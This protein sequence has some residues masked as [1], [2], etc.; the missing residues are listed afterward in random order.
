MKIKSLIIGAFCCLLYANLWAQTG[1]SIH[2]VVVKPTSNASFYGPTD[3]QLEAEVRT[4]EVFDVIE[5]I[6]PGIGYRNIN[7][8]YNAD[9]LHSPRYD[10]N[11]YGNTHLELT[12]KPITDS[13]EWDKVFVRFHEEQKPYDDYLSSQPVPLNSWTTISIPLADYTSA[14][15]TKV[16]SINIARTQ[17]ADSFRLAIKDIRFTG[18]TQDFIWFGPSKPGF[19]HNGY[20][21][22]DP[23]LPGH[24]MY[25]GVFTEGY[26]SPGLINKVKFYA[27]GQNI[28]YDTSDPYELNWQDVHVGSYELKSIAE[29][30][31]GSMH[32]SDGVHINVIADSI[33]TR[34]VHVIEPADSSEFYGPRAIGLVAS[35]DSLEGPTYFRVSTPGGLRALNIGHHPSSYFA[36]SYDVTGGGNTHLEFQYRPQTQ[37]I[38]WDNVQVAIYSHKERFS[39][40]MNPEDTVVGQWY[41]ASIPLSEYPSADF[42]SMQLIQIPY[43]YSF[44]DSAAIDIGKIQFVGGAEP[45]LWFGGD[46]IDNHYNGLTE[47]DVANGV[48]LGASDVYADKVKGAAL[49]K[50]NFFENGILIGFDSIAPFN[51]DNYIFGE[52]THQIHAAAE[53]ADGVSLSSDPI[54]I[55]VIDTSLLPE[56]WVS[57]GQLFGAGVRRAGTAFDQNE[58]TGEIAVAWIED[59]DRN[60]GGDVDMLFAILDSNFNLLA[61]PQGTSWPLKLGGEP[62]LDVFDPG[63]PKVKID[64]NTGNIV[65]AWLQLSTDKNSEEGL[66]H[67]V[68][69]SSGESLSA[70]QSNTQ[71]LISNSF[72]SSYNTFDICIDSSGT[73]Y[74]AIQGASTDTIWMNKVDPSTGNLG[75]ANDFGIPFVDPDPT[76][77]TSQR[78]LLADLEWNANYGLILGEFSRYEAGS[79]VN[80][81]FFS[82]RT[83]DTDFTNLSSQYNLSGDVGFNMGIKH[84]IFMDVSLKNDM[85]LSAW[86]YVNANT[87][88]TEVK[89]SINR[90]QA[91]SLFELSA[92]IAIDAGD[93]YSVEILDTYFHPDSNLFG[94]GSVLFPSAYQRISKINVFEFVENTNSV[95][96]NSL[97]G[98]Q[99]TNVYSSPGC[100]LC[101]FWASTEEPNFRFTQNGEIAFSIGS[102]SAQTITGTL[103]L[104]WG[105]IPTPATRPISYAVLDWQQNANLYRPIKNKLYLQY[106]SR[107]VPESIEF[108]FYNDESQ[109]WETLSYTQTTSVGPNKFVL[110]V[111]T[112]SPGK[113]YLVS[114]NNAEGEE[115]YFRIWMR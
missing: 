109:V 60:V 18:G 31:D 44:P 46:K 38:D 65:V 83:M 92:P 48:P 35:V 14:D 52:G 63:Y 62:T 7:I 84:P 47:E 28:G 43:F 93:G 110:D 13:I 101:Q 77:I 80:A 95:E 15:L 39:D 74:G 4:G 96:I 114:V 51:L 19:S 85:I 22:G 112:L 102:F 70:Y 76:L 89:I 54:Q 57:A 32:I 67:T 33:G 42:T 5:V 56:G 58:T 40:Y 88:E 41:T 91:D 2:T 105:L 94:I 6:N 20:A 81:P 37:G 79:T 66:W 8:G 72:T 115:E 78:R 75:Q 90:I 23:S 30:A 21:D 61:P 53:Y 100:Y 106:P 68:L 3:I 45:F 26:A 10:V 87:N 103:D 9:H 29:M 107:K 49:E 108:R 36:A 99:I 97:T 50:V 16:S 98:N 12:F 25:L 17:D 73:I 111:K 34:V 64:Q 1:D 71:E 113:T 104:D 86:P 11:Q 82:I 69:N 27:N 59:P 55:T 24:L